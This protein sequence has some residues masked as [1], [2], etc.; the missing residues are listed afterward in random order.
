MS[1]G[2]VAIVPARGSS[3]VGATVEALIG[4]GRVDRVVVVDD[5]SRDDTGSRA[6]A[7]GAMV[8]RPG[9][10]LGKGGAVGV[11]IDAAPDALRYLLVD[12][13]LGDTAAAVVGLLDPL[14]R[15][16]AEMTVARFPPAAGRGGFGLIKRASASL[17]EWLCGERVTE[18]LSGQRGVDGPLL[19]SLRLAPRFGLEVGLTVD[20]VRAGAR[21]VELPLP[22]D[23]AHTGRT[24]AGFRHRIRQ[25]VDIVRAASVR[26]GAGSTRVVGVAALG[27]V[28]ALCCVLLAPSTPTPRVR[29]DAHRSVVLVTVAFTKLA[30][31]EEPTLP[32][33]AALADRSAGALA[34]RTPS[35]PGDQAS[36]YSTIGA[37][38][39]VVMVSPEQDDVE[40]EE[41]TGL[42]GDDDD[43]IGAGPAIG[44]TP[45]GRV[46]RVVTRLVRSS[47]S[48][49][50][51]RPGLL[52]DTLRAAG[53]GRTYV[54]ARS[55]GSGRHVPAAL[56]L[57]DSR[58]HIDHIERGALPLAP[59]PGLDDAVRNRVDAVRTA[60]RRG[61]VVV[62]D[63]GGA[64]QMWP[65]TNGP[66]TDDDRAAREHRRLGQ[67]E[68]TDALLGA[69]RQ[70][71]LDATVLVVG[72]APPGAWRLTPVLE[73]DS[74]GQ[75]RS[76]A[77]GSTS[78]R[79][80]DESLLTDVAPTLL[81]LK[82]IDVPR[83]M[84]GAPIGR[85]DVPSSRSSLTS[86]SNRAEYR[87]RVYVPMI[88]GF[89]IAQGVVYL[90]AIVGL[91][92]RRKG[93]PGGQG[94]LE[95]AER[96]ALAFCAFPV[97]TFLWRLMP[98][99]LQVPWVAAVGFLCTTLVLATLAWHCRHHPLSPIVWLAGLTVLVEVVDAATSGALQHVSLLGYTPV[100][101]ARFY[102]MGNMGYAILG[103]GAILLAGSWAAARR[104]MPE[105]PPSAESGRRRWTRA[106]GLTAAGVLFAVVLLVEVAPSMG[107]DF[108]GVLSFLPVFA[109]LLALWAGVRVTWLRAI[110]G[111]LLCVA[112]VVAFV[113][114]E[115]RTGGDGHVSRFAQ[116]GLPGMWD[117][118]VRKGATNLRVMRITF[119]TWMVPIIV[120]FI[121]GS[122]TAGGGWRRWFGNA[123]EW[124]VTFS[125]LLAFGVIGGW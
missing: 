85:A 84:V 119:W 83:D 106:E 80:V 21:V 19:R 23:H 59:G 62:L 77:L 117:T 39:P 9:C 48:R 69:L 5:G 113:W 46:I 17:I 44:A 101:A 114:W 82:G 35:A 26:M 16:D 25:G 104:T 107:A 105:A 45:D 54:G 55:G 96:F 37:G 18:P 110:V 8:V 31:L 67:I 64:P 38:A 111:G 63:A 3:T 88:M 65:A 115:G 99:G 6:A 79:H 30:D 11:G 92:R 118:I 41:I 43:T 10:N 7:A 93:A 116:G 4:T 71:D 81:A 12:A 66:M 90:L 75:G 86:L 58:H 52:G 42:L 89:V 74:G 13:D 57:M 2:V 49:S 120:V 50:Y 36:G 76:G 51:G 53:V 20:A 1:G 87:D 123:R 56:A 100:T 28:T 78:T 95:V 91:R 73:L 72:L 97:A 102:G 47:D 60:V 121:V 98:V 32:N 14:E 61:D 70:A 109:G 122:L 68:V 40:I 112:A 24:V 33:M 94:I 103:A 125:G 29:A 15:G 27:V 108:G 34:P 22:L 124:G